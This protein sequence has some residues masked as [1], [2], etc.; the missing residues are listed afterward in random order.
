MKRVHILLMMLLCAWSA[1]AQKKLS[2]EFGRME[3]SGDSIMMTRW[4]HR[5]YG[6]ENFSEKYSF[7]KIG[8]HFIELNGEP[9]PLM[10]AEGTKISQKKDPGLTDEA[11]TVRF[12]FPKDFTDKFLNPQRPLS[13]LFIRINDTLIRMNCAQQ[14]YSE[15]LLPAN[16]DKISFRLYPKNFSANHYYH[17]LWKRSF[18]LHYY[19]SPEYE[20]DPSN[21]LV[22]IYVPRPATYFDIFY[23]KNEFAQVTDTSIHWK[24]VTYK[25]PKKKPYIEKNDIPEDWAKDTIVIRCPT[26]FEGVYYDVKNNGYRISLTGNR[27]Y[28]I[29]PNAGWANDTLAICKFDIVDEEFIYIK[30]PHLIYE[31][32]VILGTK[33][34]SYRGFFWPRK[35]IRVRF[36]FP[37]TKTKL[38]IEYHAKNKIEEIIYPTDSIVWIS[39]KTDYFSYFIKPAD[40]L[41]KMHDPIGLFYG[42]R[43]FPN[44]GSDIND[45]IRF[46]TN[47]IDIEVPLDDSYFER[48]Y[49]E[50]EY[51]RVHNDTISWKGRSFVKKQQ[52]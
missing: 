48:Y 46:F 4:G 50:G 39:K 47:A 20:I 38:R 30:Y 5:F 23:T 19:D 6:T 15:I 35:N 9:L 14:G 11:T 21:N 44:F 3:I 27:F 25:P 33:I 12:S 2:S 24:H 8:E 18:S 37:N 26:K 52:K 40:T 28:Y 32:S 22:E 29:E 17:Q 42:V 31:A 1:H 16:T 51:V 10:A 13:N 45:N 7:K 34:K 36:S 43:E 49:I 41:P